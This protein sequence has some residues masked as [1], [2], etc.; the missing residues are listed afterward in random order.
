M[1][2]LL[3]V[4]FRVALAFGI[5]VRITFRITVRV[6]QAVLVAVRI[7]QAVG[8]PLAVPVGGRPRRPLAQPLPLLQPLPLARRP[9]GGV[10]TGG[11]GTSGPN[12]A[13]M[14]GGSALI[15]TAAWFG[16]RS[17]RRRAGRNA[18]S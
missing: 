10:G 1:R 5:T 2:H 8:E 11:G 7:A 4:A 13:E 3:G 15:A 14:L 16:V 6:A 18:E 12:T 17:L 9:H